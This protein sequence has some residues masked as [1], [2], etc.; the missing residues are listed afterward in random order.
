M[1][2]VDDWGEPITDDTL[3]VLLNAQPD[4]VSFMLPDA[5][6]GTSWEVLVDTALDDEASERRQ[7]PVGASVSLAGRSFQLLR[8]L[9]SGAP[10]PQEG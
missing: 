2:E 6:P 4:P 3:L 1:D 10:L 5:H 7:F 9:R 8:A